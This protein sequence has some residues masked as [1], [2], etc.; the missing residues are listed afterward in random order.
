MARSRL[1][2]NEEQTP[3]SGLDLRRVSGPF[4]HEAE[5]LNLNTTTWKA[6]TTVARKVPK[7][8]MTHINI[9]ELNRGQAARLLKDVADQDKAAYVQRYGKPLVVVISHER[10]E[11]LIEDGIDICEH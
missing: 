1:R 3:Q 2:S 6:G 9:G 7:T 4:L 10:Y 11:R 5:K 8:P